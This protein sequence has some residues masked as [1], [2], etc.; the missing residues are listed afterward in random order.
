MN[1][2]TGLCSN[3]QVPSLSQVGQRCFKSP[4]PRGLPICFKSPAL[5]NEFRNITDYCSWQGAQTWNLP[6]LWVGKLVP[7]GQEL[8]IVQL[9]RFLA[10]KS[11]REE[12]ISFRNLEHPSFIYR[13]I[14]LP[15]TRPFSSRPQ[16]P[17]HISGCV[18]LNTRQK[19]IQGIRSITK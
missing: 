7:V 4:K 5:D 15:I 6:F 14:S 11:L 13:K 17:I 16:I 9:L 12:D 18:F 2:Q 19:W 3:L 1:V 10:H 8:G